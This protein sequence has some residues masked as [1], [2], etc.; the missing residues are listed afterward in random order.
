MAGW[1]DSAKGMAG[2][3]KGPKKEI[4]SIHTKKGAS[5]GYIHTHHHVNPDKHPPEDH[6]SPNQDAMVQHMM[7]NMGSPNPGEA[8]ADSGQSGIP[9]GAPTPGAAAPAASAP[10]AP[11]AAPTPG[12]M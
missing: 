4:A 11:M 5:G 6:V 9:T 3:S 2:S 12:A 10:P 8:D 7:A 1:K